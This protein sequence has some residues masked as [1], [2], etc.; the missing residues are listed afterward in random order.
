MIVH[1]HTNSSIM[2]Y[3]SL[4]RQNVREEISKARAIAIAV[5]PDIRDCIKIGRLAKSKRI[6]E[7]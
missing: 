3:G 5:S 7:L 6:N 2:R 4:T 1:T